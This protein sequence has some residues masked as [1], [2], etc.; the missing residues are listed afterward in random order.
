MKKPG[1]APEW[2][3]ELESV[4]R[5]WPYL[6]DHLRRSLVEIVSHYGPPA[7]TARFPTPPGSDWPDV[8]IVMLAEEEARITVGSVTQAYSFAAVGLADRRNPKRPRAEWRMLRT[9]AEN[10]EPDAYYRL[11][12]RDYLKV[13]ISKFRRWLQGFFG[14]PG[15][16]LQ[17]FH[18]GR[19][20]P[21]FKI[22]TDY[23]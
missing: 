4:M 3:D 2:S 12:T 6:P 18:H 19:W 1:P 7:V 5:R 22:K 10:P 16:P 23:R 13:D 20:R 17:T 21:R 11:P 9:Y 15:D 14:I 8:E